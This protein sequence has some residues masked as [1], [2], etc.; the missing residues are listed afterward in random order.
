[1]ASGTGDFAMEPDVS[2]PLIEK[3][4]PG[5]YRR[6]DRVLGFRLWALGSRF[7]AWQCAEPRAQ[8]LEPRA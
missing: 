5:A 2:H 7:R 4:R 6:A 3:A 8:S 1:M